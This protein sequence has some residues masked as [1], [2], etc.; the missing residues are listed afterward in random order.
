[1]AH[2]LARRPEG[3]YAYDVAVSL[4][5]DGGETWRAPL[6]P[7]T[8]GTPTEHGF[9]TT[10]PWQGGVGVVWLDGRNMVPGPGAETGDHEHGDGGMTLRS[11]VIHDD[12]TL[13]HEALIDELTC[14]CC[15]TDVALGPDGPLVVYRDRSEGEIRDI[16][17]S[18]AA[19]GNWSA[20]VPVAEDGW[21]IEGCPVNGPAIDAQGRTVAVAW[22]TAADDRPRVRIAWSLDGGTSFGAPIDVDAESPLGRVDVVLLGD[23]DALVNWLAS[24][25]AGAAVS[26]R[27][28]GRDGTLGPVGIVGHT[29][30]ARPAGFPQMVA[31][32]GWI[33]VSWTE[34][35]EDVTRVRT[36][37]ARVDGADGGSGTRLAKPSE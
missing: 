12:G 14:D 2:W 25:D 35:G 15:Q 8:D 27:R 10:F 6:A 26:V 19:E 33:V 32:D 9:V 4:S 21:M 20:P 30:A 1:M 11:A 18:R 31:A 22:F 16:S 7:H 37:R 28:I 34:A 17:L 23:R 5:D 29:A 13:G 3:G 36:A 24:A